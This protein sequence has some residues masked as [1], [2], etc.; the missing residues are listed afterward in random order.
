MC[1]RLRAAPCSS[2]HL[3]ETSRTTRSFKF[4]STHVHVEGVALS[5]ASLESIEHVTHGHQYTVC[6][7]SAGLPGSGQRSNTEA[8]RPRRAARPLPLND[9]RNDGIDA[10]TRCDSG[11]SWTVDTMVQ[12]DRSNARVKGRH[13][14]G[15]QPS[16]VV[17]YMMGSMH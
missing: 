11:C 10:I 12:V 3:A 6:T 8:H 7:G 14:Y 2:S 5:S 17:E 4:T 9:D 13:Y 1:L 15:M 16:M